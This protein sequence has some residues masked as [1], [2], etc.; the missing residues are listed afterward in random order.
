MERCRLYFMRNLLAQV[1]KQAP[2]RVPAL[3]RTIFVQPDAALAREQLG[4]VADSLRG[5]FPKAAE[6]LLEAA[7]GVLTYVAFPAEHWGQIPSTNPPERLNRETGRRTD[8]VGIFPNPEAALRL[9]GAVRQEQHEECMAASRR[10]F[11]QES[12]AKLDAIRE[13]SSETHSGECRHCQRSQRNGWDS[14]GSPIYTTCGDVVV[15]R[16]GI[17]IPSDRCRRIHPSS[18][19]SGAYFGPRR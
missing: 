6:R 19:D 17:G 16:D 4:K 3:V 12:M 2:A 11:G 8:V 14:S 13:R 7:Y 10:Y 1:P 15:N 5:C 18:V 9:I